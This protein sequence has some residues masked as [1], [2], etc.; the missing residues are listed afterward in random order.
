M[1]PELTFESAIFH[2]TAVFT[3]V[4]QFSM[5]R[6]EVA[7]HQLSTPGT[8]HFACLRVRWETPAALVTYAYDRLKGGAPERTSYPRKVLALHPGEW[9]RVAYNGRHVALSGMSGWFYRQDVFNVAVTE[10]IDLTPF[11]GE[12]LREFSDLA[13]L[14]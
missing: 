7:E 6:Q 9:G 12:P 8:K 2:H 1:I 14:R 13:H 4:D 11:S 10:K 5:P 3:E